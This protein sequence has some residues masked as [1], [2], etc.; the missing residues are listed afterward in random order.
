VT[1]FNSDQRSW[2]ES[3]AAIPPD[4]K[5]WCGWDRLGECNNPPSI[6]RPGKTSADRMAVWCQD[7]HDEPWD[8]GVIHHRVGCPRRGPR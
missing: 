6:C 3:L 1:M 5:C 8:D 7:C 2:M 4:R